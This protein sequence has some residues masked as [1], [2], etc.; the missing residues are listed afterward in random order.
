MKPNFPISNALYY[1]G[2]PNQTCLLSRVYVFFNSKGHVIIHLLESSDSSDFSFYSFTWIYRHMGS[3]GLEFAS[4]LKQ[5]VPSCPSSS[6]CFLPSFFFFFF[7]Q[8]FILEAWRLSF[9]VILLVSTQTPTCLFLLG[10]RAVWCRICTLIFA[11]IIDH[12]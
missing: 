11:I 6:L 4:C 10:K 12:N 5:G 1:I 2:H 8:C 9:K 3:L 7:F